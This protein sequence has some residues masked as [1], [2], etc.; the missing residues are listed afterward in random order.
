MEIYLIEGTGY[1]PQTEMPE[2]TAPAILDFLAQVE[3][4]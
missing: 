4:T 2:Q 1:Y 3:H